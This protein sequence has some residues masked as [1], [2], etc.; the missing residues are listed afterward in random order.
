MASK[1]GRERV[2]RVLATA[3]PFGRMNET[4]VPTAI[5]AA[6]LVQ[7]AGTTLAVAQA[8]PP[9]TPPA[10]PAKAPQEDTKIRVDENQIVDLHVNDEDLA[11][12]LEM[13]SIQSQKNIVASKNVSARVTANLYGVTFFEAMDAILNVNG[14]GYIEQGNFIFVYTLEELK[15]IEQATKIRVSKVI[16]L[17]Y[18]NA[19]DAA[20]F[21]KPLLSEGGQIKTNGRGAHRRR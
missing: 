18:L 6:L 3:V 16:P 19:I 20:E 5:L 15:T 4:K 13:L 11:N 1:Q 17:N 14:Y 21:V 7:F 10:S 9:A 2:R 12:V 8:A